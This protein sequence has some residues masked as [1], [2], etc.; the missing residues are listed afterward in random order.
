MTNNVQKTVVANKG[1]KTMT[2]ETENK[3]NYYE[4]VKTKVFNA[5]IIKKLKGESIDELTIEVKYAN[6]K[7]NYWFY[8]N[9]AFKFV[10]LETVY[11]E[12]GHQKTRITIKNI[13]LNAKA[14]SKNGKE[15]NIFNID[16]SLKALLVA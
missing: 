13:N 4:D 1:E 3:Y 2:N 11:D 14:K 6:S 5:L 9:N 7:A 10:K 15:F 8:Q 16:E 12:L